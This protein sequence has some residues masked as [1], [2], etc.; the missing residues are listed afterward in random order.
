MDPVTNV[1][2][3]EAFKRRCHDRINELCSTTKMANYNAI[4]S[5]T[6]SRVWKTKNY[7]ILVNILSL[8]NLFTLYIIYSF[9][10][11]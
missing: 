11:V 8:I 9:D 4:F 2:D 7:L 6:E 10:F 1:F 5:S 3:D